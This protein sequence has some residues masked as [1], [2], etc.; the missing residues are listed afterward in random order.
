MRV[1][2]LSGAVSPL[3]AR[4]Y[5]GM[6]TQDFTQL[7][8]G[9]GLLFVL[10]APGVLVLRGGGW[11]GYLLHTVYIL[12]TLALFDLT[13]DRWRSQGRAVIWFDLGTAGAGLLFCGIFLR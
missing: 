10:G 7:S 6:A 2:R 3:R 1:Q 12:A 8:R 9:A 4:Q 13:R 11:F 5:T